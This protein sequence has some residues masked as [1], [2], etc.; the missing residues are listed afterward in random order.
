M[1]GKTIATMITMFIFVLFFLFSITY[2]LH[3][4]IELK[5]DT[6]SYNVI[7]TVSTNGK[8]SSQL[9]GYLKDSIGKYGD[10]TIIVKLEEQIR[11]GIYDTH[12]DTSYIIDKNLKIGDKM[13]IY[14][15]DRNLSLFGRLIN[16]SIFGV[17]GSDSLIDS[18]IKSIKT[19]II[20]KNGD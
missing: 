11:P 19:A 4:K 6:V 1:S 8:L 10:Y 12:Y 17:A 3:K 16:A 14:L 7:E 13:S 9:Y 18:R 20:S 15:E 5:V 2:S